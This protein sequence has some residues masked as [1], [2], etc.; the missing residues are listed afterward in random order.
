MAGFF[1]PTVVFDQAKKKRSFRNLLSPFSAENR[2]AFKL[3]KLSARDLA[4]APRLVSLQGSSVVLVKN[5]KAG[6]T[7]LAQ[8]MYFSKTGRF[9]EQQIHKDTQVLIQGRMNAL[10]NLDRVRN[11][12]GFIITSVRHPE[13][14]TYSAFRNLILDGTNRSGHKH[15]KAI[16]KFGFDPTKPEEFNFDVFLD[17]VDRSLQLDRYKTDRHWREQCINTAIDRIDYDLISRLESLSDDLPRILDIL[18]IPKTDWNKIKDARFNRS[19]RSDNIGTPRQRLRIQR[20]Y[21]AD[22]EAFGY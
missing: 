12:N 18:R 2:E 19:P 6:C 14:R 15:A 17:Y 3:S 20:L 13:T 11:G 22:Y 7:T 8:I 10:A 1:G 4:V 16:R 5:S 9:L 21:K